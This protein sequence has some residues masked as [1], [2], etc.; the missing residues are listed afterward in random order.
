MTVPPPQKPGLLGTPTPGADPAGYMLSQ[1]EGDLVWFA[2]ALLSFKAKALDTNGM[3]SFCQVDCLR[4]W[5][6]PV[7][8]HAHEAELFYIDEGDV[9][10]LVGDSV[11]EAT[12]GSVVWIP[13]DTSHS[14]FVHSPT[15]RMLITVTPGGFEHF[16]EELGEPAKIPAV[17][18]HEYHMP[19]VDDFV[20]T[21]QKYGWQLEAPQPRTRR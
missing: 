18:T 1:S 12:A 6:A 9:D 19:S 5:Q 11:K 21:G 14:I 20:A 10:I 4:G 3:L 13:P 2:G 17:P 7:H 15:S 16:F 8:R